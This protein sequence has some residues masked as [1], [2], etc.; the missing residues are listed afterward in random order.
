MMIRDSAGRVIAALS[1]PMVGPLGALEIEAKAMDVGMLFARDVGIQEVVFES[2]SLEL[3]NSV[4][5]ISSPSS[6]IQFIVDGIQ[7]RERWFSSCSFSYTKKQ[8][9]VPACMLAQYAKSLASYV[10]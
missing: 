7:Q 2:D 10:A 8:G 3:Y 9:K 4:Q 1:S 6:S 5:G